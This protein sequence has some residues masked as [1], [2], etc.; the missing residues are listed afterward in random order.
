[1]MISLLATRTATAAISLSTKANQSQTTVFTKSSQR[2][3]PT[4]PTRIDITR[5]LSPVGQSQPRRKPPRRLHWLVYVGVILLVMLIG[6]VVLSV[7]TGWW[8]IEQD[9]LHYGRPRTF[10]IDAIVGHNDAVTPTHFLA[11]NLHRR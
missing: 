9:D 10:Q 1:M 11:M 7:S 5:G 2:C 4:P 3:F 6:W 8:Q